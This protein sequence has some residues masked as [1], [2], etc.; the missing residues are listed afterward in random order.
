MTTQFEIYEDEENKPKRLMT[1]WDVAQ[2]LDITTSTVHQLVR[3]GKMT[4]VQI[5]KCNRRFT[6]EMVEEFIKSATVHRNKTFEVD[7]LKAATITHN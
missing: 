7:F 3:N 4:C 5:N 2:I 1:A 6:I